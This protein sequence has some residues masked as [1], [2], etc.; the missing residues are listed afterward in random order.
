MTGLTKTNSQK[1]FLAVFFVFNLFLANQV[2][3][4][5]SS[6]S[7]ST[8]NTSTTTGKTS[9]ISIN[10][11]QAKITFVNPLNRDEVQDVLGDAM[12]VILNLVGILA[13]L[14]LVVAGVIW[15]TSAGG[16][17]VKLAK[18]IASGAVIGLV[19]T[20]AAPS[21]LKE[22]YTILGQDVTQVGD[23]KLDKG[24]ADVALTATQ[25][26]LKFIGVLTILMI[27]VGGVMIIISGGSKGVETGKK[28]VLWSVIGLVVALLSLVI[29]NA[30]VG[31]F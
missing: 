14:M 27:I 23:T 8:T 12:K 10:G 19:I 1:L 11:N 26:I 6:S 2:L 22:V 20:V 18:N 30:I 13:I 25:Q 15:I 17:R 24:L 7:S 3:G 31:V 4:Q 21:I 28:M 5:D 16:D 29:V 9:N